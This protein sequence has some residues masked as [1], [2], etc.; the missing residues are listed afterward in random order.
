MRTLLVG[1]AAVALV[2]ATASAATVTRSSPPV[3]ATLEYHD[4]AGGPGKVADRLTITRDGTVLFDAKPEPD[5]C[6]PD[7]CGPTVG[8]GRTIPP[9]SVADLEGDE[10][11]EVIY[12]AYTGGAHC[13]FAVQIYSLNDAGTRYRITEENFGDVGFRLRP[14]NTN[15]NRV[16]LFSADWRFDSVF[17]AHAA[18][19]KPILILRFADGELVDVTDSYRARIRR[20]ARHWWKLYVRNRGEESGAALGLVA[21]WAA[22]RYRL[23]KR[24]ATLRLLKRHA[25]RGFL[26]GPGKLQGRRFVR[27]LDGFLLRLGYADGSDE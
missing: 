18:S 11:P 12:Q 7:F 16:D 4:R 1:L 20:D 21:A 26:R 13:C 14:D 24:D 25:R 19:G 10:E 27:K 15:V 5:G 6:E 17:T 8:F 22:D 2:P 3:E 23:G 9:L